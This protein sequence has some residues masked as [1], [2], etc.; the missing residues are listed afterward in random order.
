MRCGCIVWDCVEAWRCQSLPRFFA[1]IDHSHAGFYLFGGIYWRGVTK[2][3]DEICQRRETL[4][5]RTRNR[6]TEKLEIAW[7]PVLEGNKNQGTRTDPGSTGGRAETA[8]SIFG[9]ARKRK[10]KNE[11]KSG[12]VLLTAFEISTSCRTYVRNWFF[13]QLDRHVPSLVNDM[14]TPRP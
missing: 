2:R 13:S 14:D 12:N 11:P 5:R 7:K 4:G 8:R 9:L 3:R 6:E 1:I 10:A